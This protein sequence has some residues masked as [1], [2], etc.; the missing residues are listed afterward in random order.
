[1]PCEHAVRLRMLVVMF[2]FVFSI[3]TTLLALSG[4]AG[5]PIVWTMLAFASM[6]IGMLIERWLFIAEAQHVVTLYY[7]AQS[8]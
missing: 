6:A 3:T 2:G 7:G 1:M 8:A 4:S 5:A